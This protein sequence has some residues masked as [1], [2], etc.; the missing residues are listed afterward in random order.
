MSKG[1]AIEG[2]IPQKTQLREAITFIFPVPDQMIPINL[3][4]SKDNLKRLLLETGFDYLTYCYGKEDDENFKNKNEAK[5]DDV[6]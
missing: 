1:L 4:G 3:E 6:R 5:L 2:E